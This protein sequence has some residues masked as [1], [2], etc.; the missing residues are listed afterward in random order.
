MALIKCPVC[1]RE[2]SESAPS[3]PGCGEPMIAARV[4]DKPDGYVPYSDQEVQVMLSKRK[5]TNH[6][7]H[8]LLSVITVGFWVVIWVLVAA[9]NGTENARIDKK[10]AKGKKPP[11]SFAA[12]R[13]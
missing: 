8:L 12:S 9:N 11:P 7:L 10:I 5:T 3:C 13:G 4:P 6:V 1:E 2:I